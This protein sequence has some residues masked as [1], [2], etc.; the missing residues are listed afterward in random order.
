M[1]NII[2]KYGVAIVALAIL[3]AGVVW[4]FTRPRVEQAPVVKA[5][6]MDV[7]TGEVTVRPITDMPPLENAA[8]KKTIVRAV[9]MSTDGGQTKKVA[10]LMK[11]IEPGAVGQDELPPGATDMLVRLPEPKSKWVRASTVEGAAVM[12]HNPFGEGTAAEVVMPE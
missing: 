1:R 11:G 9:M 8:G 3:T 2:N 12:S 6:F 4:F 7:E 5:F 10:Y